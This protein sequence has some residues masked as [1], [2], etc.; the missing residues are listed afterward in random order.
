LS[1]PDDAGRRKSRSENSIRLIIAL[2]GA[3]AVIIAAVLTVVLPRVLGQSPPTPPS[4]SINL[5]SRSVVPQC[6]KISGYW[7]P[8]SYRGKQLWLFDQ[9]PNGAHQ[10]YPLSNL[11]YYL[12][13]LRPDSRGAWTADISLGNWGESG[14]P[15]W[16]EIVS[17]DLSLTG[18][19]NP[20]GWVGDRFTG[21]PASVDPR[22][23]LKMEVIV[24][25]ENGGPDGQCY[26]YIKVGTH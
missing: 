23:L 11:F 13:G 16:L 20:K 4:V 12:R 1:G 21:L 3:G 9:I 2:I 6:A 24:G 5:R 19:I 22:P 8:G 7:K 10:A 15:Y 18:R 14:Y 26:S 25:K 17:S